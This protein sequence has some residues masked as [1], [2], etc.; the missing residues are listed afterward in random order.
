MHDSWESK[1]R[2]FILLWLFFWTGLMHYDLAGGFNHF[3]FSPYL[4][5]W[6]NLTNIFQMGRNHQLVIHLGSMMFL[7]EIPHGNWYFPPEKKAYFFFLHKKWNQMILQT[8]FCFSGTK[9]AAIVVSMEKKRRQ[10]FPKKGLRVVF[11]DDILFVAYERNM[12]L[13]DPLDVSHNRDLRDYKY[14][15]IPFMMISLWK[16]TGDNSGS[17][18]SSSFSRVY[19]H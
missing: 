5:K 1:S 8:F 3:L 16:K 18:A 10:H 2:L 7:F 13:S 14:I 9:L 4:G 17:P 12:E 11:L 6:S 19:Q 15:R